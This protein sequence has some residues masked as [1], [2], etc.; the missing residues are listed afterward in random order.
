MHFVTFICH[1]HVLTVGRLRL[2]LGTVNC[3]FQLVKAGGPVLIDQT[4]LGI[5][6][7]TH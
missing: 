4:N 6:D 1:R 2:A 5:L 3:G 7:S